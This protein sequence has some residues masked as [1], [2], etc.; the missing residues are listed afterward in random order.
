MFTNPTI[1]IC[2][3]YL[4]FFLEWYVKNGDT[5]FK[6]AFP[7]LLVMLTIYI[8]SILS[9]YIS[10]TI[11]CLFITFAFWLGFYINKTY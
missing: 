5:L 4:L 7:C 9:N 8:P 2:Y 6:F 3:Y 10:S 1:T 11:N